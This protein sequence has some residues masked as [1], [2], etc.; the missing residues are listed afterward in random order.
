M[1]KYSLLL[2]DDDPYILEGIGEDLESNG[3][4]VTRASSGE[5]A[6]ELLG[7]NHFDLVI[8]DLVMESTDGIQVL[9]K[10]KE[11]NSNI[12][13]IILTGFGDVDSAIVALRSQADDFL[14]KPCESQEML[15]RVKNCLEKQELTRKINLY[16]KILP[17]CCVCKKIRDDSG[18][19]PGSGDWITIE[20]F[21]HEQARLDITSSY[22][23][24][25][26]KKTMDAFTRKSV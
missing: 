26:A 13:V 3:Y 20:Q 6:V 7:A 15:F 5:S 2:V 8:T 19:Q 10:T 25:C 11:L 12:Q 18:R 21:I 1:K 14:L 9:K 23:P 4:Q 16:Q 24:D 22:C 17:M